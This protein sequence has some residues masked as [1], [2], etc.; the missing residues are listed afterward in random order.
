MVGGI[1]VYV[2]KTGQVEKTANNEQ[3]PAIHP[4]EHFPHLTPGDEVVAFEATRLEGGTKR[5]EYPPEGKKTFLFLLSPS[6]GA[7]AKTVPKWNRLASELEGRARVLGIVLGR[8]QSE[9]ERLREKRLAFP[10]VRFPSR[11]IMNRY[12]AYKVPQTIV[13]VPGGK[14]EEN[15]LGELTDQQVDELVARVKPEDERS[16]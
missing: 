13:V 9:Q 12:K 8:Y 3:A 15:I 4:L 16:S 1:E 6:C 2:W 11:E 10:V 5:I 14:V 7:C